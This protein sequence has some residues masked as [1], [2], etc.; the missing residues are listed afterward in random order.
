LLLLALLLL[1]ARWRALDILTWCL[2]VSLLVHLLLWLWLEG[3]PLVLREVETP[4]GPAR[5]E[6]VVVDD[7]AAPAEAAGSSASLA[8]RAQRPARHADLAAAAP[9][10]TMPAALPAPELPAGRRGEV[11]LRPADTRPSPAL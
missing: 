1:G 2:I 11:E 10:A 3:L 7:G 4:P 9:S 8:A 6:L 5:M